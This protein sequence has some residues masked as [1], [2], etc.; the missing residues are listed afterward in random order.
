MLRWPQWI[1]YVIRSGMIVAGSYSFPLCNPTMRWASPRRCRMLWEFCGRSDDKSR[2]CILDWSMFKPF[3]RRWPLY[4]Y[5]CQEQDTG[6]SRP[7][8]ALAQLLRHRL[9]L[10]TFTNYRGSLDFGWPDRCDLMDFDFF[11]ARPLAHSL[12]AKLSVGSTASCAA[13]FGD[14]VINLF[15]S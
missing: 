12:T 3:E 1:I 15:R 7:L 14:N 5:G 6:R 10:W 4:A 9:A 2:F 11:G 8:H 13:V